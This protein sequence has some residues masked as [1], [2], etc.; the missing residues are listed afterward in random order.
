MREEFRFFDK[1]PV[2]R[3]Y[4]ALAEVI[5][6]DNEVLQELIGASIKCVLGS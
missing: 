2:K 6:L 3:D 1:G 5:Y 4:V